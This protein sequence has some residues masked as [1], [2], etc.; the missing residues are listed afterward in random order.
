MASADGSSRRTSELPY[1]MLDDRYRLESLIGRG[2]MAAVYRGIDTRLD[3]PVA[4]KMLADA[5]AADDQRF[6]VEV[7]TLARFSHPNLVRL[8]DAGE[9]DGR[10][11]LVMGYVKGTTQEVNERLLMS[12]RG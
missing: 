10:L 2:G 1:D 12:S 9:V 8:L 7:R 4:I 11:Y 6:R 3:R 5:P